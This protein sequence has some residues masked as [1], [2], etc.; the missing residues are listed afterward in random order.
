MTGCGSDCGRSRLVLRRGVDEL[1][2]E[3]EQLVEAG[4][5]VGPVFDGHLFDPQVQ[6]VEL[7]DKAGF[8]PA[9]FNAALCLSRGIGTAVDAGMAAEWMLRALRNPESGLG[10]GCSALAAGPLCFMGSPA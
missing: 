6:A 7:G 10:G 8:W 5:D 9:Q 2:E 1:A 3:D 4:G